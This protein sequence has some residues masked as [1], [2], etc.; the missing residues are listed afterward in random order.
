MKVGWWKD[1]WCMKDRRME[2]VW[3]EGGW[4]KG[5]WSVDGGRLDSGWINGV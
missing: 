4:R 3:M 5:G 2:V 1:R